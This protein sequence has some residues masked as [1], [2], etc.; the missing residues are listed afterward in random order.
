MTNEHITVSALR[1]HFVS[2]AFPR[3]VIME[4]QFV[5]RDWFQQSDASPIPSDVTQ[6]QLIQRTS[7]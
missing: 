2:L 5:C 6:I 4:N 3:A 7:L 1:V